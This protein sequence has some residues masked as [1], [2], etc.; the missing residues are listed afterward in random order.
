MDMGEAVDLL[1]AYM[2]GDC[3]DILVF[4]PVSQLIC[5]CNRLH[6][7]TNNGVAHYIFHAF[8][9]HIDH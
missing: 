5:F 8:S 6:G 9:K 3:H 2:G 7:W 4:G 1:A